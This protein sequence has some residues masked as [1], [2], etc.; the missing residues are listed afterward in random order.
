MAL[1]INGIAGADA[2]A[3]AVLDLIHALVGALQQ[4][5]RD[6]AVFGISGDAEAGGDA[7]GEV[8]R[9]QEM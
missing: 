8:F 2:V 5:S 4:R 6:G 3:G 9:T 7:Q 1:V